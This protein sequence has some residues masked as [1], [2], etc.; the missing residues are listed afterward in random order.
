[1]PENLPTG[2]KAALGENSYT[3]GSKKRR[4]FAPTKFPGLMAGESCRFHQ[5]T[6]FMPTSEYISYLRSAEWS[7]LRSRLL[8]ERGAECECCGS[9]KRIQLHHLT[10]ERIFEERDE[11][12]ML[13]CPICHESVER[14]KDEG[15]IPKRGN[16]QMLRQK[17]LSLFAHRAPISKA[18]DKGIGPRNPHQEKMMADPIFM[19]AVR[20]NARRP[21]LVWARNYYDLGGVRTRAKWIANAIALYDRLD[22]YSLNSQ[23]R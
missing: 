1:M 13:L 7:Q 15:T 5:E 10:Y 21:F 14:A 6:K 18:R 2:E 9:S 19:Q 12:L 4:D 3:L 16:A 23:T 20:S 11:D 17:T 22:K 8:T